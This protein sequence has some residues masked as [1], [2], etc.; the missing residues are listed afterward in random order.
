MPEN[1]FRHPAV[2]I[3]LFVIK[4]N[5]NNETICWNFGLAILTFFA[6]YVVYTEF[7]CSMSQENQ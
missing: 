7:T 1:F 3:D 5:H 6:D 2:A 4:F